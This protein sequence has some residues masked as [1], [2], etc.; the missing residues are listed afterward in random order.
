MDPP[1]AAARAHLSTFLKSVGSLL[2]LPGI[3]SLRE[4]LARWEGMAQDESE[5]M[6]V[7]PAQAV[8]RDYTASLATGGAQPVRPETFDAMDDDG[9]GDDPGQDEAEPMR[10]GNRNEQESSHDLA[11]H[12]TCLRHVDRENGPRRHEPGERGGPGDDT[13][14]TGPDTM[15]ELEEA[16]RAEAWAAIAV[17]A[18]FSGLRVEEASAYS[19]RSLEAL[20]SC[21]DAPLPEVSWM[22][23]F[24][25]GQVTHVPVALM[26]ELLLPDLAWL[27][28]AHLCAL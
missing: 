16:C 13:S 10:D 18:L 9:G 11:S 23:A 4:A 3:E 8:A 22:W 25:I 7:A 5:M 12:V 20:P 1:D 28:L 15:S 2:P 24:P 21:L 27:G 26:M 6:D 14:K 19:H 17:G